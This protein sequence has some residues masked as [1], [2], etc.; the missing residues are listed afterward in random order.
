MTHSIAAIFVTCLISGLALWGEHYS[1]W[2]AWFGKQLSRPMAYTAGMAA[3]FLP[4]SGLY[5]YWIQFTPAGSLLGWA[6]AGLW[7]DVCACGLTLWMLKLIDGLS[8]A[9]ARERELEIWR[10][11]VNLDGLDKILERGHAYR[12]RDE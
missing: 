12:G 3:V 4:V 10:K 7:I 2:Q 11:D 8:L 5:V 1:P 6:L 9:N